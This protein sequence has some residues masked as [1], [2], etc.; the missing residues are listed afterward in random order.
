MAFGPLRSW[1]NLSKTMK[2]TDYQSEFLDYLQ[3]QKAYSSKTVESYRR[4]IKE[5]LD[6]LKSQSFSIDQVDYQFV[7]GYLVFLNSRQL[8]KN[9]INHR[10]SVQR[11]FFNYLVNQDYLKANP[12]KLVD[13]LRTRRK[14]PE[15]LYLDEVNELLD[16]LPS[17]SDLERRNQLIVE[18]LYSCGLRASELVSL[19][20]GDIDLDDQMICVIGKGNRQRFVPYCDS[21]ADL[22]RGYLMATRNNLCCRCDFIHEY[23]FVNR[24]GNPLTTRGLEKIINK[25]GNEY[26]SS[27]RLYPHMLRHS[28]ATHLIEAGA[29]I[30]F[31]QELLGHVS[32]STTQIY[33]HITK[34]HLVAVYK[35]ANIRNKKG[36]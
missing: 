5:F 10:L 6:Y 19:K 31:V 20:I 35:K 14:D 24:F 26:G 22:L 17:S 32:L 4:E 21:V 27:K 13:S 11:S 7:R 30:R 34:E 3:H 16:S 23:V 12:F 2:S 8:K 33:T 9:S 25:I 36:D 1:S 15:F 29:D 28:L 18:M